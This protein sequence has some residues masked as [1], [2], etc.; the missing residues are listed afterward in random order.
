MNS[1]GLKSGA[2]A[3]LMTLGV[4]METPSTTLAE[5]NPAPRTQRLLE[6]GPYGSG[7]ATLNLEDTT[8]PTMETSVTVPNYGVVTCPATGSRKLEI[9]VW[10][11]AKDDAQID[12]ANARIG[13]SK[14]GFPLIVYGHGLGSNNGDIRHVASHL[15][16]YGYVVASIKFP[17]SNGAAPCGPTAI[18]VEGQVGDMLYTRGALTSYFAPAFSVDTTRTALMGY[19][20]G[21]VTAAMATDFATS[22]GMNITAVATLAPAACGLYTVPEGFDALNTSLKRPLMVIGGTTDLVTPLPDNGAKLFSAADAAT[23][24]YLVKITNGSHLGFIADAANYESLYPTTALDNVICSGLVKAGYDHDTTA[25]ECAPCPRFPYTALSALQLPSA[26]HHDLE[27]A[28]LLAFFDGYMRDE[29]RDQQY[30][31]T[32]LQGENTELSV[33]YSG[34]ANQ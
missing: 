20:L 31:K 22:I 12:V 32:G 18:D 8:R 9:K 4:G 13:K 3:V 7:T 14:D 1:F 29:R 24:K 21:G 28:A 23:P 17:L 27:T 11:P 10:Y 33:T 15:A 34:P 19:S 2:F 30:L 5:E 25:A 6:R 16:S 26:R